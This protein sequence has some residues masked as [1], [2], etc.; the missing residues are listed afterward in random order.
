MEPELGLRE[1]KKAR[2]RQ[3]IQTTAW[4]LFAERGFEGVTVAEIAREAEVAQKTVFNYF[5]TK[6]DLVFG[7]MQTFEEQVLQAVQDRRPGQSVLDAFVNFV[8]QPRQL[9]AERN[10]GADRAASEQLRA[11]LRMIT[12][13]PSLLAREEQIYARFIDVLATHLRDETGVG[14]DD[15]EPWIAANAM[16]GV[17]RALVQHV[18]TRALAGISN[19]GI[20]VEIGRHGQAAL[21]LLRRGLGRYAVKRRS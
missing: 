11:G 4:R 7:R 12:S 14:P 9:L 21:S 8:A 6:E 16:I 5:P 3:V 15:P 1:R 10:P 18:R 17:H 2:T 13:S 20:G 19:R